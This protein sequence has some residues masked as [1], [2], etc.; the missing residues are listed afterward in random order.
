MKNIICTEPCLCMENPCGARL[1]FWHQD[2]KFGLGSFYYKGV[3]AG[4][5]MDQFL[6]EDSHYV[7]DK[8]QADRYEIVENTPQKGVITFYGTFGAINIESNWL[9]T[10]TLT[11]GSPAYLLEYQVEPYLWPGRYH[12]LYVSAPFENEKL[13]CVSY[14]MEA[15]I[16]PP[17]HSHWFV[18]P[19]VGKVPFL[20]G[21]EQAGDSSLYVGIGYTWRQPGRII[22]R[23]CSGMTAPKRGAPFAQISHI[24]TT[25][26]QRRTAGRSTA[27]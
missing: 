27:S 8:Y 7:W 21:R 4:A 26:F 12:P 19:D 9:V 17:Y 18:R 13:E 16:L 25:G 6:Y 24:F 11:A 2:G 10:V 15:P 1:E 22:P 3:R 23:G 14:P 5:E 20:L